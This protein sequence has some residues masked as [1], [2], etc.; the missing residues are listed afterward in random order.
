[1]DFGEQENGRVYFLCVC[2]GGGGGRAVLQGNQDSSRE[3]GTL[4]IKTIWEHWNNM[5]T[6]GNKGIGIP[7]EV[8][9]GIGIPCEGFAF[10]GK[11]TSYKSNDERKAEILK[12]TEK[13]F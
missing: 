9:K 3:Q 4:M 13:T 1:M 6:Q 7:C 10:H 11:I 5:I 12:M 8:N 2:G